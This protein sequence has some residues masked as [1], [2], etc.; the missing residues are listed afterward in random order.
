MS[1]GPLWSLFQF[2]PPG[3][4]L[5]SLYPGA[6]PAHFRYTCHGT[7][8]EAVY[9]PSSLV[10]PTGGWSSPMPGCIEAL[11]TQSED[12]EL[13]STCSCNLS[14]IGFHPTARNTHHKQVGL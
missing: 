5:Q 9:K 1:R 10:G 12:R 13:W 8:L 11:Q 2:L 14:L 6:F 4:S 3:S 7:Y